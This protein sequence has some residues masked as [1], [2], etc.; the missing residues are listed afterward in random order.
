MKTAA[1]SFAG[2]QIE[3]V[4]EEGNQSVA[5]VRGEQCATDFTRNREGGEKA[6]TNPD[7]TKQVR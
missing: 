6:E 4:T 7:G 2:R 3:N 1:V 5:S